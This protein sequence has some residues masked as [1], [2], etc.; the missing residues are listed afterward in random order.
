MT[1]KNKPED[2][3]KDLPEEEEEEETGKPI[4]RTQIVVG[5]IAV[6]S[7]CA[8]L[9]KCKRIIKDLLQDKTINN[10]LSFH[11]KKKL[12]GISIPLGVG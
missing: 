8:S 5:D 6:L 10:Y 4:A 2:L 7:N 12:L 1:K 9:P 3:G 11:S